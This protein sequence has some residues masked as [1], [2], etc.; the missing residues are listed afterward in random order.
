MDPLNTK[1]ILYT[2]FDTF[3]AGP[4]KKGPFTG[5]V[6]DSIFV[7]DG[8]RW[9]F[10]R[11]LLRPQFA[12]QHIAHLD[13]LEVITN[14][15]L[16]CIPGDGTSVD[17]QQY[18]LDVALDSATA[19]FFGESAGAVQ[20]RLAL[21]RGETPDHPWGAKFSSAFDICQA[22]L[23]I[24]FFYRNFHAWYNPQELIDAKKEC[25]GIVDNFIH[26]AIRKHGKAARAAKA[27]KP[28]VEADETGSKR[29]YIFLEELVKYSEDVE[30]LRGT[31]IGLLVAGRGPIAK[32]LAFTFHCLVRYPEAQEKLR[33]EIYEHF[34]SEFDRSR[35][36]FE[37]LKA[38]KYLRW[39]ID[40]SLRLYPSVPFDARTASKDT[41][42]PHGGGPDGMSP[43]FIPKGSAVEY[44]PYAAHRRLDIFGP[45]AN[46]FR[47]ERFETLSQEM[48]RGTEHG[49]WTYIPFNA[50]PR[51]CVGQ[52]M[53]L[54]EVSYVIVRMF[55]HFEKFENGEFS[56]F[57][58][59]DMSLNMG[60]GGQG[61][62]VRSFA[63]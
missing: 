63:K 36:T 49:A 58:K 25:F 42:L 7:E 6:N 30:L 32:T 61:A 62:R 12:R 18:F 14:D 35:I 51:T 26:K 27:S 20:H 48:A 37:S 39:V 38:C 29:R 45:D 33:K 46:W 13:N 19:L 55:Q 44:V 28:D 9:S 10:H 59:L 22:L 8:E 11:A 56:Q 24:K 34:G 5:F 54:T 53:S 50:G 60:L 57:V 3:L 1:H 21:L 31:I 15:L 16:K 41:Y 4:S 47:P 2:Q 43:I 40:E 23:L 52:Q 17:L